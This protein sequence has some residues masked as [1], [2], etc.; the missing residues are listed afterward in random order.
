MEGR[1]SR[2]NREGEKREAEKNTDQGVLFFDRFKIQCFARIF[3][4]H[5]I[6]LQQK[7]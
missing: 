5:I 7:F 1:S 2:R 4:N 3:E 6:I